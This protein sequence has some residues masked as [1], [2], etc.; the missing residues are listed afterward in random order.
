MKRFEMLHTAHVPE[1]GLFA[2]CMRTC[3]GCIF[4][5]HPES[6]PNFVDEWMFPEGH[7][8]VLRAWLEARGF[9]P[10]FYLVPA[11]QYEESCAQLEETRTDAHHLIGGLIPGTALRHWCVGRFGRV[12]W[13]PRP[14]EPGKGWGLLEPD[15]ELGGY[16]LGFFV[17]R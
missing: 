3:V 2:D 13:D 6:I 9:S 16:E 7:D 12:V 5:T 10:L 14:N 1:N 4:D 17:K 8:A 15:P 11:E